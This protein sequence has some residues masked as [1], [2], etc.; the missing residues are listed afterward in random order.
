MVDLVVMGMIS[1]NDSKYEVRIELVDEI[2]GLITS[3]HFKFKHIKK[4]A[5]SRLP[6][7]F[8]K[9]PVKYYLTKKKQHTHNTLYTK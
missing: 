8:G 4:S 1:L 7:E 2:I 5:V 9:K 6:Y 3:R